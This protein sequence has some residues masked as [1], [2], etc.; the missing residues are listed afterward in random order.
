MPVSAQAGFKPSV[1]QFSVKLVD[2]SYDVPPSTTTVTDP[3]TGKESIVTNSGYHVS[4]RTIEVTIKNQP[5][6]PYKKEN[7]WTPPKLYYKIQF[8]GHFE[9]KWNTFPWLNSEGKV[10]PSDSEY[11][12][13]SSQSGITG[14]TYMINHLE[15][16]SQLDFRVQAVI[17]YDKGI[18]AQDHPLP[19]GT[20]FIVE[21]S[22]N[23]SNIQTIAIDKTGSSSHPSQTTTLPPVNSEDNGQPQYP[24]QTQPSNAIFTNPIFTL[25]IGVLLGG[26]V[27]AV[28]LVVLRRHIRTST[29]TNDSPQTNTHAEPS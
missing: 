16:G 12:V 1:P 9:E 19:V 21:T 29:Y 13:V 8:K 22:S 18:F 28:V 3:Y 17:G 11:T 23:W 6:T 5:F 14:I 26:I 2:S 20:E 7:A 10:V 27:V 25:V 4:D 15:A 24:S